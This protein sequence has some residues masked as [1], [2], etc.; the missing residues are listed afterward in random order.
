MP[1]YHFDLVKRNAERV[2][3]KLITTFLILLPLTAF[4]Y[5]KDELSAAKKSMVRL[6]LNSYSGNCPCPYN[7][8]RNGRP[9]AGR[10]AYTK[11]GGVAPY[12][13]ERDISD[14]AADS[15]LNSNRR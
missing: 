6:S 14:K 9:C 4:S 2:C 11:P 12:C 15:W 3:M 8:M 10:S 13:Y 1:K 7:T 5:S